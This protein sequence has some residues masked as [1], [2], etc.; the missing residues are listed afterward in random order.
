SVPSASGP[1]PFYVDGDLGDDLFN[2]L[3]SHPSAAGGPKR[4]VGAGLSAA[5]ASGQTGVTLVVR[6]TASPYCQDSIDP[7]AG[8]VVI[9]PTGDVIIQPQP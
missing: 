1:A 5:A 4:T 2:G 9:R 8:Q 6:G 3:A 7:G